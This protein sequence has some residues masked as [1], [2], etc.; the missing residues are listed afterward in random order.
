MSNWLVPNDFAARTKGGAKLK[1]TTGD[2]IQLN[3]PD[4]LCKLELQMYTTSD[5]SSGFG[6]VFNC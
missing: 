5:V 1:R 2:V 3:D 6:W 4:V